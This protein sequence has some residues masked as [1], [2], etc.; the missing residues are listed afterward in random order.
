MGSHGDNYPFPCIYLEQNLSRVSEERQGWVA[1]L[2]AVNR[3][4]KAAVQAIVQQGV[5]DGTLRPAP[6]ARGGCDGGLPG[7]PQ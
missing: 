1:E 6:D 7:G 5:D 2:C 4:Y 3:R